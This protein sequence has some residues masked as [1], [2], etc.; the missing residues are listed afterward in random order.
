VAHYYFDLRVGDEVIRD[1]EGVIFHLESVQEEAA[2]ALAEMVRDM[3]RRRQNRAEY[4]MSIEVRDD[5]G[6]VLIKWAGKPFSSSPGG[7]SHSPCAQPSRIPHQSFPI[8]SF[9]TKRRLEIL[10]CILRMEGRRPRRPYSFFSS[11]T[12]IARASS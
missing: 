3:I 8:L 10:I 9:A 4:G 2:R 5:N 1:E 7:P 12:I 11:L 6:P